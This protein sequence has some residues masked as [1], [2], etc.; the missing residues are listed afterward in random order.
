VITQFAY[1]HFGLKPS[2]AVEDLFK[3]SE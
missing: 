2:A 1:R 3:D